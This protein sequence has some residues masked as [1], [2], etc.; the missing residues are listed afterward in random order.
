MALQRSP[1]SKPATGNTTPPN[2]FLPDQSKAITL[3]SGPIPSSVLPGQKTNLYEEKNQLENAYYT[4]LAK[5][6]SSNVSDRTKKQLQRTL[7]VKYKQ[8]GFVQPGDVSQATSWKG[9]LS[10][11]AQAAFAP[12]KVIGET[13]SLVSRT[14]QSATKEIADGIYHNFN[15]NDPNAPKMSWN[16]FVSQAK[17]KDF[18]LVHT[19][20]KWVDSTLDFVTDVAFDPSTYLGVGELQFIGK[21]GRLALAAKLG[22]EEMMTKYPSLVG[23][24]D[25]IMRYG[26]AAVPKDVRAAEGIGYGVRFAGKMIP[27]T[28]ALASVFV[29]GPDSLSLATRVRTGIGD[30]IAKSEKLNAGR[31]ALTP[32]TKVGLVT[33]M[34]GRDKGLS[35]SVVAQ[36]VA[37]W[38]ASKFGKGYKTEAY[39]KNLFNIRDTIRSYKSLPEAD[40]SLVVGLIENTDLA[41]PSHLK[42]IVDNYRGWQS[43][44]RDGVNAIYSKFNADFSARMNDIGFVDDFIHHRITP[45]ALKY[46]F[47]SAGERSGYFKTGDLTVAEIGGAT[48][49]AMHRTISAPKILEDGTTQY[50][51]F[52]GENITSKNVIQEVN[53]IFRKKTGLDADFFQNDLVAIADSYAYSMAAA[54]GREA[55]YRRLMDYGDNIIKVI[56]TKSVPNKE[57]VGNLQRIAGGLAKTRIQLTNTIKAGEKAVG[58]SIDNAVAR[59]NRILDNK[60]AETAANAKTISAVEQKLATLEGELAV[61]AEAAKSVSADERGAFYDIHKAL[62]ED[63]LSLRRAIRNGDA[64]EK[65]SYDELKRI[66]M[67]IYPQRKNLPKTVSELVDGIVRAQGGTETKAYR[68]LSKRLDVL[69]KQIE[70]IPD[71]DAGALNEM[72]AIEQK[73][74]NDIAGHEVLGNVRLNADY[75]PDGF[76]YGSWEDLTPREFDPS[77][78][79][80]PYRVLS[81]QP[82]VPGG[83]DMT[84][85]EIAG[86]RKAFMGDSNSVAVHALETSA[87]HDMRDPANFQDFWMPENGF[88]DA[89]SLS[90]RRAGLDDSADAWDM[91]WRDAIETGSVDPTF[92]AVYPELGDIMGL[93]GTMVTAK[94]GA[95]VVDDNFLVQSFDT[96]RDM[97]NNV[98]AVNSI[99][100]SDMVAGQML[101]DVL[102]YMSEQSFG[103]PMLLPS[104]TIYGVDNPMADGAYSVIVPENFSYAQHH[105]GGVLEG[106]TTSPVHFVKDNEF[107]GAIMNNDLHSVALDASEK[108]GQTLENTAVLQGMKEQRDIAVQEFN[109]I[110]GQKGSAAAHASKRMKETDA[111]WAQWNESQTINVTVKGKERTL[112]RD[113]ALDILNASQAQLNSKAVKY[114]A[115]VL[116]RERGAVKGI[117]GR[118]QGQRE[119]LSTLLNQKQ[120]LEKWNDTAGAYL[121]AEIDDF[122]KVVALKPPAGAAATET[123]K[124]GQQ[125]IDRLNQIKTL[126]GS[127]EATA[128]ERVFT[129]LYANEA[130]LAYHD[131]FMAP[132][133]QQAIDLAS[134]GSLLPKAIDDIQAG[135]EAIA[136]TGLQMPKEYADV[137]KPNLM[138]L[139]NRANQGLFKTVLEKY[140]SVFKVYATMSAGFAVRNGL[141]ATFMNTVAGV[142]AKHQLL[143]IDAAIQYRRKG[144]T[145][146]I[147]ALGNKVNK[148][149]A[150]ESMRA[151]YATGR[152][153][154][155]EFMSPQV[156]GALGKLTDNPLTRGFGAMN[157]FVED[158]VRFAMAYD[159]LAKGGTFD[160]AVYRISRYHFD[161][162]DLSKVDEEVKRFLIP[163]WIWTTR[164]IPL[165]MTEQLMRPGAYNAYE[166]LRNRN[167]IAGDVLVP[168][169]L[170]EQGPISLGGNMLLNPDLP[171]N[172]LY[173][174]ATGLLDPKKLAGQANPLI[175]VVMELI[176]DK[177]LAM[178][179]PFTDKFQDARGLDKAL[180]AIGAATGIDAL[181]YRDAQGN[182]QV[183]PR[184]SYALSTLLPPVATAERLTGGIAGGKTTYQERQLSSLLSWLG[185][186]IRNLGEQQQRGEAINRQFQIADLLKELARKGVIQSGG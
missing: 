156:V 180:A 3:G 127:K 102:G 25:N 35:D 69:R 103:K 121:R 73:L 111:A 32:S 147:D 78:V 91:A 41:V 66:Y 134:A 164:N 12:I 55:Y 7:E 6:A 132:A 57:L 139:R 68:E 21:S 18:K 175:K 185:I 77:F 47:S 29:G 15:A 24:L 4:A 88:G 14:L 140:Q 124:W 89:I 82:V 142:D 40:K 58:K 74:T 49:T 128:L 174:T 30:M 50:S 141:S 160:D 137:I 37:H 130:Q 101:D 104:Q 11:S 71:M 81:T 56:N 123:R 144:A 27:K 45:D 173:S 169:W 181:G 177:Q 122:L 153:I 168:K 97:L 162:S 138:K 99:E 170:A 16:D 133:A 167:P 86:F 125:V 151:V 36:E 98:A 178:D 85:D 184:A 28:E 22:T 92:D 179:I 166:N 117:E 9:I 131:A 39:A 94:H 107:V 84:V 135:W 149:M 20:V 13:T 112:T 5:I 96:L 75:S 87:V 23:S 109:K 161:Y 10:A 100:N 145:K 106:K 152:G 65:A 172:R 146:W 110:R 165:Q 43:S 143:G 95:G 114:E 64:L 59:A 17:N 61:A 34:V 31:L 33:K 90:M 120:V 148:D 51:K 171:Q 44:L 53:A 70:T 186:P 1:F 60:A 155:D 62:Y 115:D 67:D 76:L 26:V 150:G 52:M 157:T 2:P 72:I 113:Q 158:S 118:L 80:T 136:N 38:T 108:L 93:T 154:S 163:F 54:R 79:G 119:R 19:G 63:V 183:N 116:A 46:I 83:P 126:Q 42:D 176:A 8:G 129:T 48:G 159:T 105:G 182:L